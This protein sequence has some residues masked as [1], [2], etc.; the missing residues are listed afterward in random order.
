[1]HGRKRLAILLVGVI[2]ASAG[3]MALYFNNNADALWKIVS[4]QCVVGEQQ[5]HE[6]M[7][8]WY[9]KTAMVRYSFCYCRSQK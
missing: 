8:M 6:P 3:A 7:V 5:K 9:L 4:Q 2:A 1:M